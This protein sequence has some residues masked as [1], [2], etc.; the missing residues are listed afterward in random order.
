MLEY[1]KRCSNDQIKITKTNTI[2]ARFSIVTQAYTCHIYNKRYA[3]A[4]YHA[5]PH[6]LHALHKHTCKQIHQHLGNRQ[7]K[8]KWMNRPIFD[9]HGVLRFIEAPFHCLCAI[10]VY[11]NIQCTLYRSKWTSLI[12]S[13]EYTGCYFQRWCIVL[14]IYEILKY[15]NVSRVRHSYCQH[16]TNTF[17]I[18]TVFTIK[19][20]IIHNHKRMPHIVQSSHEPNISFIPFSML[21]HFISFTLIRLPSNQHSS[22]F[23]CASVKIHRFKWYF[24]YICERGT[25]ELLTMSENVSAFFLYYFASSVFLPISLP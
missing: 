5:M 13:M 19:L 9:F 7:P 24:M 25:K 11:Y 12:W 18:S 8:L 14:N 3:Y 23:V 21:A 22:R 10:F 15:A 6:A 16:N 4:I 1:Q 20:I 17:S 2:H